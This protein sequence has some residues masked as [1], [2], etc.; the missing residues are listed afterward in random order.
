MPP[1]VRADTGEAADQVEFCQG[2]PLATFQALGGGGKPFVGE[3]RDCL[4]QESLC[5]PVP[6][7]SGGV[8]GEGECG[9]PMVEAGARAG[10]EVVA[11]CCAQPVVCLLPSAAAGD[12]AF[13]VQERDPGGTAA[14]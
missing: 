9:C 10:G 3:V 5:G 8:E 11:G 13:D 7:L 12:G 14:E 2:G 6:G 1:Q 4:V